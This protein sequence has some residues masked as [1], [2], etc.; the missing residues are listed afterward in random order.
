VNHYEIVGQNGQ[1]AQGL[2]LTLRSGDVS[3][4]ESRVD[5]H[6]RFMQNRAQVCTTISYC[7]F[8]S[9]FVQSGVEMFVRS[10]LENSTIM[11]VG[12][13][14]LSL[15][16]GSS[17]PGHSRSHKAGFEHRLSGFS[18]RVS[19]HWAKRRGSQSRAPKMPISEL[20]AHL[21][22]Q[23]MIWNLTSTAWRAR[24]RR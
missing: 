20:R 14:G 5:S 2:G 8:C 19:I 11:K 15:Q 13:R 3:S 1:V 18:T 7:L 16:D 10:G 22:T 17:R 23:K 12:S 24:A 6:S 21:V 9:I 4:I